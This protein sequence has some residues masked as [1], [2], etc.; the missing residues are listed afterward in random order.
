M[1]KMLHDI[2]KEINVIKYD[3]FLTDKNIDEVFNNKIDFVV[4][5]CDTVKT[6]EA[7]IKKCLDCNIKFI[8]SMGTGNRMD[9]TKINIMDIRETNNDPLARIIRKW[10]KDNKIH[11]KIPVACSTEFPKKNGNKVGSNSFVPASCGLVITSY[12]INK[13]IST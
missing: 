3:Y 10:V 9:P 1:D 4:D 5:A 11:D 13:I 6:K 7:I 12:I 2:N 8:S